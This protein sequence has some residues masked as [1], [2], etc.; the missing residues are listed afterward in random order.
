MVREERSGDGRKSNPEPNF[1]TA[2]GQRAGQEEF[3]IAKSA[4]GCL[5][6]MLGRAQFLFGI[7]VNAGAAAGQVPNSGGLEFTGDF[8]IF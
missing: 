6:D 2:F 4:V 8:S 3:I 5:H 7:G 1:G